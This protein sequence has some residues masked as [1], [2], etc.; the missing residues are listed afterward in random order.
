MYKSLPSSVHAGHLGTDK[1]LLT[2]HNALLFRQIARDLLH[3]LSHRHDKTWTAFG[4]PVV[5]TSGDKLITC[6]QNSTFLKE[7]DLAELKPGL[8]RRRC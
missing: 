3:A 8:D 6:R 2:G 7:T 4:E 1:S 5:G